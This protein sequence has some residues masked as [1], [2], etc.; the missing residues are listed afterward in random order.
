MEGLG[1]S[2]LGKQFETRWAREKKFPCDYPYK[3]C[4][5]MQVSVCVRGV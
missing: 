5:H 4:M 3:L 2:V 1:K